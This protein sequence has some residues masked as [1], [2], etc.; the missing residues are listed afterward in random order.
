MGRRNPHKDIDGVEHKRC[1]RC[2]E[3]KILTHF[4]KCKSSWDNLGKRCRDCSKLCNKVYCSQTHVKIKKNSISK[5]TCLIQQIEQK[6]LL[7]K[8]NT[9][10]WIM[11]N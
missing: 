10:P 9:T 11:S 2:K 1:C 6:F 8:K 5:N 4:N 7:D 3:W